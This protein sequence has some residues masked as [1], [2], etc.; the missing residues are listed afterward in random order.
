[1]EKVLS[2]NAL[3]AKD[4][5]ERGNQY[6]R[7][8]NL[9]G[10]LDAFRHSLK[11]NPRM[12]APWLGLAQ[13]L[14]AN[15]QFEDAKKCLQQATHAEPANVIARRELAQSLKNLGYVDDAKKEF[16][17][18]LKLDPKSAATHFGLGQLLEDL[19]EPEAAAASYRAA[20]ECDPTAHEASANIL[21][22]GR[23]LDIASE[24]EKA[25]AQIST[26]DLRQRSL[27]GY[28]LGKALDHQ[29]SYDAAFDA[30]AIANAARRELSGCFDRK[31][32]DHRVEGM[33]QLFSAEFFA[34]R[35]GWGDSSERPIFI[36]GLPR[37]GTTLTEQILASHPQCF[38]A[39]ELAVLTDLATGTPDRLGTDE[40]SWPNC[41]TKLSQRQLAELG[42]DYCAQSAL[43]APDSAIRIVDKQPLNFWHLGLVATA[44]PNAR[45]I[46][47]TR[48]IRDCGF[49]IFTQNFNTQQK[50]STDLGDIACYWQG[51][52]KLMAHWEKVSGLDIL[53]VSYEDT[54]S[55]LEDQARA[56]LGF[57]DL[58]WDD[59]VL[60]FHTADRAVQTPSRWQ[61]RQPLYQTSKARWRKYEKHLAPL[62]QAAEA[63]Q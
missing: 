53:E 48:D 1:M 62:I 2:A 52:R 46:H 22:L 9:A 26:D 15:S 38:G 42:R 13:V 55:G 57:V 5:F 28:G 21:G 25:Q 41:A 39:G 40:A 63:G 60:Q 16:E 54:V 61:V 33:I 18:A 7:S 32:F 11:L 30:Y 24:I 3:S 27:L 12:A 43:R 47:C 8:G 45:I 56:M 23:H 31:A 20:L 49:S 10:A 44:L 4:W 59:R 14:E 34:E 58:P 50:W 51:Y 19:G 36:V 35:K 37:S 17:K 6:K 29:K